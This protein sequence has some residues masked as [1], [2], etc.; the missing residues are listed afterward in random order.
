MSHNKA[1]DYLSLLDNV[2]STGINTIDNLAYEHDDGE[3]IGV[4]EGKEI[5]KTTAQ[6]IINALN[7]FVVDVDKLPFKK[8]ETK[9]EN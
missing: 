6:N 4:L 2:L 7:E 5:V 3:T 9:Y 1:L 8:F